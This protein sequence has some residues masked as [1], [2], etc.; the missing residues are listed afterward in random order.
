MHQLKV[1]K[2]KNIFGSYLV[3]LGNWVMLQT[4]VG[5]LDPD[6]IHELKI[7]FSQFCEPRFCTMYHCI[8][9]C[10]KLK[11]LYLV[12]ALSKGALLPHPPELLVSQA[13]P[14]HQRQEEPG[15]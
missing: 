9:H 13:V 6:W 7:G 1:Q 10:V 15:L 14:H 2:K 8:M 4:L 5:L 12:A 11:I 3:P